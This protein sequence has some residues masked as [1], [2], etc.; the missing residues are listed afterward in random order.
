MFAM[1]QKI[2]ALI[3]FASLVENIDVVF[4]TAQYLNKKQNYLKFVPYG[5][6]IKPPVSNDIAVLIF[7]KEGE[8]NA[9][10]GLE[11]DM[12]N[13][14]V[15]EPGEV[16]LGVPTQKARVY[17]TNDDLIRV[18]NENATLHTYLKSTMNVIKNLVTGTWTVTGG[19]AVYNG[20][21]VDT[22]IITAAISQNDALLK[23]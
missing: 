1:L 23:D 14:D 8:E 16:A 18:F 12:N 15:L 19:A 3:K 4:G 2:K 13:R 7:N 20:A 21:A 17:M 11:S 10:I 22:P 6:H 5:M 9:W